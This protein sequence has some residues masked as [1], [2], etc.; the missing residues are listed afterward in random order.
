MVTIFIMYNLHK[1]VDIEDYKRFHY[2]R[3]KPTVLS[4]PGIRSFTLYKVTGGSNAPP[5]EI[6]ETIE[7]D[8]WEAWT[9]ARSTKGML[10]LH[11]DWKRYC[12]EASLLMN[13][14]ERI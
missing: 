11:E 1:S 8:S 2:T 14:G 6:V 7:A 13:Y 4:Q 3:D 12:D 9:R 5:R 10:E